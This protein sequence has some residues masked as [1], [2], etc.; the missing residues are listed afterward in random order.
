MSQVNI[1]KAAKL[2]G[3]TRQYLHSHYIKQG[4][5]SVTQDK[6]GKPQIDISE[7][8]RVFGKL[9]VD[10][11]VNDNSLHNVTPEILHKNND[12]SAELRLMRELLEEK[13]KRIEDLQKAMLMLADKTPKKRWWQR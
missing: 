7:I 11:P 2:A 10:N 5:I 8:I 6:D 1:T 13:D 3:I 4:R 9:H 12:V